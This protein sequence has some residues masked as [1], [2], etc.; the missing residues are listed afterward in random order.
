MLYPYSSVTALT[1]DRS[2][3][4]AIRDRLSGMSLH[5]K[6]LAEHLASETGGMEDD[7]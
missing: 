3:W 1:F 4:E 6:E 2:A 5:V 7:E